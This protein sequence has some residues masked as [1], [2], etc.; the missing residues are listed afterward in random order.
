VQDRI[1]I[2]D[3]DQLIR[4]GLEKAFRE[5]EIATASASSAEE[6]LELLAVQPCNLCLL[7]TDLP[8]LNCLDLVK[9]IHVSYPQTWIMLMT[10][11]QPAELG[12]LANRNEAEH[13]G[14]CRLITKPFD[15]KEL[16]DTVLRVLKKEREYYADVV[17]AGEMLG[18]GH[19]KHRRTLHIQPFTFR[20]NHIQEGEARRPTF[21]AV[22]TDIGD[23]GIGLLTQHPVRK[24]DILSFDE[25]FQH[26]SGT[27]VWSH[28]LDEQ[29]CRAG[30]RFA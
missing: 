25:K 4:Y 17:F 18:V 13:F 16:M 30:V 3:D 7:D 24:T 23:N 28:M 19:R 2:V 12:C 14:V 22:S 8:D 11:N 6:A 15:L 10:A 20:T 9:V 21:S 26:R 5:R 27:V 29:T 1:L